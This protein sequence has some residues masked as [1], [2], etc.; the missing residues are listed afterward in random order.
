MD[1]KVGSKIRVRDDLSSC[2]GK[3]EFGSL[4]SNMLK[5]AGKGGVITEVLKHKSGTSYHISIDNS[6]WFWR[7]NMF[8]PRFV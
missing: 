2:I 8:K 6:G 7:S 1:L 5:Y 3:E 4:V